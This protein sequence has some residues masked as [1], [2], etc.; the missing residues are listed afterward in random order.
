MS[1]AATFL[2]HNDHE[3]I[4]LDNH[5]QDGIGIDFIQHIKKS[6]PG[7]KVIMIT[8]NG[9]ISDRE[10]AFTEGTDFFIDKPFTRD[11]IYQIIDQVAN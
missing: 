4:F 3:I 10:K 6:C 1:D 9:T 2:Q 7:A 8:A 5:L 11:T